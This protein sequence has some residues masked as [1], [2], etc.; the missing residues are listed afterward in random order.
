M[1]SFPRCLAL[2]RRATQELPL[3]REPPDLGAHIR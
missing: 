1:D 2:A 3:V